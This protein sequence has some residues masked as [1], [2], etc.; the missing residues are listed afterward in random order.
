V[1]VCVYVCVCAC[2]WS[3]SKM[4]SVPQIAVMAILEQADYRLDAY[5]ETPSTG[6]HP[7]SDFV[8]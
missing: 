3:Y 5:H 4:G 6:F 8:R 7:P 2:A 1:C